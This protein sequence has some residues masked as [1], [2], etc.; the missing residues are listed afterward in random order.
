MWKQVVIMMTQADGRV[1]EVYHR[2][3]SRDF[4]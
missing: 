4:L 2:V 3:Y 1:G